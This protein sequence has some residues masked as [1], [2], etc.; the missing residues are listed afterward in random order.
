MLRS[1]SLFIMLEVVITMAFQ[2]CRSETGMAYAYV[3]PTRNSTMLETSS[4]IKPERREMNSPC[5]T[6]KRRRRGRPRLDHRYPL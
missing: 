4:M 2:C 3:S 6:T 5:P 1:T